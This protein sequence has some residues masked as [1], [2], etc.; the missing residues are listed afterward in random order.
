MN[1]NEVLQIPHDCYIILTT[2]CNQRCLHCYGSYGRNTSR[3]LNGQEW[4][5]IIDELAKNNVFYVN[6]SGGEPTLHNDFSMILDY[7]ATKKMFFILTSN[8]VCS[9]EALSSIIRNRDYLL[10]LKISLD[11]HD[12]KSH[13]S[14]RRDT[15]GN[16]RSDYF[17]KTMSTINTLRKYNLPFTIATCIHK[18]N[19]DFLTEMMN[20]VIRLRPVS[21]FIS[22]ISQSGRALENLDI[23]SGCENIK[24]ETWKLIEYECEQNGIYS[25]FIDIPQLEVRKDSLFYYECP[26]ARW[27]CEI[28]SDGQ[29]SPCPLAR[30]S[31][32]YDKLPFKSILHYSL[33][34][35]WW[36]DEFEQFRKLGHEGCLGCVSKS[37]CRRCVPQSYQWFDDP[38]FPPPSCIRN[39][40]KLGLKNTDKLNALLDEK[41]VEFQ[42]YGY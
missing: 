23:F 2:R 24:L 21:W 37:V 4:C 18:N 19:A 17:N 25:R 39:G 11:G 16:M 41:V 40:V 10:G 15:N 9:G 8:G 14:L 42:R 33:S 3:E 5:R 35:I 26:A 7:L 38:L 32:P 34:D 12:E 31:I 36:S 29:V 20:L 30:T 27:F 22:T 1:Q 13:G 6:I 28:H